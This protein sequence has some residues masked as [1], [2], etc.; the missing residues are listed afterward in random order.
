MTT[1][2]F[3]ALLTRNVAPSNLETLMHALSVFNQ[4]RIGKGDLLSI[5]EQTLKLPP[6][7][8]VK[9]TGLPDLVA[10]FKR[11]VLRMS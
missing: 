1:Q 4:G 8:P 7:A 3:F 5:A 6:G 9:D 11:I 10:V 2:A